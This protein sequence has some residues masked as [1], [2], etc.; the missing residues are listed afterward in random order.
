MQVTLNIP[1]EI[2]SRLGS[3]APRR[4]LETVL[5]DAYRQEFI[6]LGRL[7]ELL[8][9]SRWEAEEFID[10]NR[11]RLPHTVEMWEEDRQTLAKLFGR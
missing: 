2:A 11:A 3:D 8:D 5:L 4:V 7:G 1:P 6:S 10:K 9:V